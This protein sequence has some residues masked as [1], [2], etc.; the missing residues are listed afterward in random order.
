MHSLAY[1]IQ[2]C[3]LFAFIVNS[4]KFLQ[5]SYMFT[6]KE[7][8]GPFEFSDEL[9]NISITPEASSDIVPAQ[10]YEANDKDLLL[11][12]DEKDD[13]KGL[14]SNNSSAYTAPSLENSSNITSQMQELAISGPTT[15]ATTPQSSFGFDDLLGLGLSTAPAPT[16]SPP[17]LKLNPR[18][19]LDPGAFQQKW[20][21][22]PISLTQVFSHNFYLAMLLFQLPS[23]F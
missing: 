4:K 12:I 9:G 22:L 17:L 7:H 21:Q 3:S 16:P 5:P 8:R 1:I 10:Q 14:S 20:R 13:N 19:A 18:A 11:G 6:D 23:I 2:R 15:S